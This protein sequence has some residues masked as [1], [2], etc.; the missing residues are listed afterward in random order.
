MCEWKKIIKKHQIL[1]QVGVEPTTLC[2]RVHALPSSPSHS[3]TLDKK[4]YI[5]A[6]PSPET[7][8]FKILAVKWEPWTFGF[9]IFRSTT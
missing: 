9:P 3:L 6:K 8:N 5:K 1:T 4:F 2:F 7:H